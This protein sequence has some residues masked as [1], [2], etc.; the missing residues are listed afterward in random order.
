MVE[1]EARSEAGT[2]GALERLGLSRPEAGGQGFSSW[3]PVASLV[4]YLG[5]GLAGTLVV[6]FEPFRDWFMHLLM[7]VVILSFYLLYLKANV[8][9]RRVMRLLTTLLTVG[10]AAFFAWV[11]S[12]AMPAREVAVGGDTLWRAD[13]NALL[14]PIVLLVVGAAL[15]L[16]HCLFAG[17]GH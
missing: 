4:L 7:Y 12:D 16:V 3:A 6:V 17:R 15:Q 9:R 11:L 13:T 10:L 2:D 14:I 5:A 8:R 1:G